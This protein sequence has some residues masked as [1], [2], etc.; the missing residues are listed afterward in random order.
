MKYSNVM[1][2]LET[3]GTVGD[4]VIMSIG[5]VRFDIDSDKIDDDGFYASISVESNLEAKRR[6]QENTLIW[7]MKQSP[8][9]QAVFSEEK[10]TLGDALD[11]FAD[12]LGPDTQRVCLWSN[13][14]DFDLPMLQ[15]A[16]MQSGREI[17]WDFWNNRC[18]RTYKN[19]PHARQVNFKRE[20][21]HHNALADAIYQAKHLQ[22]IQRVVTGKE[23]FKQNSMVKAA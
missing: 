12:W 7:W 21:V 6:I 22:L 2:D 19:L 20:G 13:G 14:A 18:Y 3:L 11:G 10:Q 15:H 23:A 17:P 4:A 8:E 5:A 1:V 16:Y 9:A